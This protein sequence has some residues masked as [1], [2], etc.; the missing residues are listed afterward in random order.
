MVNYYNFAAWTL[1]AVMDF[2]EVGAGYYQGELMD[3]F[4]NLSTNSILTK[5][6][7]K[8][9]KHGGQNSKYSWSFFKMGNK[10]DFF[11]QKILLAYF[12]RKI[13]FITH[14]EK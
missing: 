6:Q 12:C 4:F 7:A 14:F 10:P 3:G 11:L 8:L 9:A 13:R 5:V 2:C 1:D